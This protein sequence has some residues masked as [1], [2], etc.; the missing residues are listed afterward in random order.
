MAVLLD[1][2]AW[3]DR[4]TVGDRDGLP[5]DVLAGMLRWPAVERVWLPSWLA[6]PEVVLD[7]LVAAL[8]APAPVATPPSAP[9]AKAVAAQVA[10]APA[11]PRPF[12]SAAPAA[13]PATLEGETA[14]VPWE[15]GV[16]GDRTVLDQL[17]SARA[18]LA[19]KTVL[20]AGIKAEGPIHVD[21]LARL[22]AAAFGLGRVAQGRKDAIAALVPASLMTGDFVWPQPD[23]A[24]G[25]TGF[26]RQPGGS[27]R[28]L[29]Q[30]APEEIGNAMVALCR[31]A[32]GMTQDEL[33]AQ[34]LDVFGY[35]RRTPAQVA[36][37]EAALNRSTR[38][39]RLGLESSGLIVTRFG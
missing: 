21:R 4:G 14:F 29:E 10:P 8:E 17:P 33:F 11:T 19:V 35:R 26:R 1:G 3:A 20:L 34:T 22:T 38:S 7:R 13:R 2:P 12:A 25:W 15:P 31:A 30:V 36:V 18:A 39:G 27:D 37:L 24:A 16:V 23:Q 9:V 28:P 6:N 5:L 32:A